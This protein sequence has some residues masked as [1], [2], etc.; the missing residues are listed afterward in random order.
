MTK[1]HLFLLMLLLTIMLGATVLW[2]SQEDIN[3]NYQKQHEEQE[4]E[5]ISTSTNISMTNIGEWKSGLKYPKTCVT[6]KLSPFPCCADNEKT[7][8]FRFFNESLNN[9]DVTKTFLSKVKF[10]SERF[11]LGN[12]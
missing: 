8:H 2:N 6:K 4:E 3:D 5:L 7:L 9:D 10:P 11:V 12:D 1:E